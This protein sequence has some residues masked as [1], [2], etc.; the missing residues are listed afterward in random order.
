MHRFKCQQVGIDPDTGD[1]VEGWVKGKTMTS[2]DTIAR[3]SKIIRS[4]SKENKNID[5]EE[6]FPIL[7]AEGMED[8]DEIVKILEKLKRAGDIF[9]PVSGH[10]RS[11][12]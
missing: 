2:K 6:L 12:K 5:I 4:L 11:L 3:V 7:A 1:A 9:E 8:E 10:F